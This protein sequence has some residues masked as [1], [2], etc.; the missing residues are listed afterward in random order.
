MSL[1]PRRSSAASACCSGSDVHPIAPTT[2]PRIA[3]RVCV[4]AARAPGRC[5][6][7]RHS[8]LA[9]T[10]ANVLDVESGRWLPDRTVLIRDGGVVSVVQSSSAPE[11]SATRVIDAGGRY[12]MPGMF[13]MHV[14]LE[15]FPGPDLL[16]LFLAHG[17]TSVRNMDGRPHILE[18]K[19][20]ISGGRL[21]GPRI[22]S[23]GPLLDGDPP[24]RDDNTVVRNADEAR[25]AVF[26]QADSG[27]DF[28]KVYTNLSAEA[29]S[30][31]VAAAR[32]RNLTVVGHFPRYSGPRRGP[33][34]PPLARAR[35]RVLA[36]DRGGGLT[37][38]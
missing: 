19:R 13:D 36:V 9:I 1:A 3:R 37:V 32:E 38:S 15:H 6:L 12:L 27:Y 33:R 34:W 21:T 30:S 14:H 16:A 24:I 8:D 7:T 18:W 22:F 17:V 20:R 5:R 11:V 35:H 4:G 2:G 31:I 23:A 25:A 28:I 29:Y 26:A 10:H